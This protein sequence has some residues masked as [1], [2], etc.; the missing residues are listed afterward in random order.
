DS[1]GYSSSTKKSGYKGQPQ[2]SIDN[3]YVNRIH[4]DPE[5][6]LP[7]VKD[8]TASPLETLQIN[9]TIVTAASANHFCALESFLY[10]MADVLDGLERTEIRPSLVVYNLGGMTLEQE[11]RLEYLQKNQYMDEYHVFD[12]A[13]YPDFWNIKVARG[14]YGWKAGIIKEVADKHRGLILWLDSGNMLALDFLR[15]LPGYLD[16]Y[17]FWS[18]QSSGNFIQYTHPGLPAFFGDSLDNYV[19]ETNCNGAAVA[20]DA[21][22]DMIYN[23]LLKDWYTCSSTKECIAP[24]GSS[25]ANHRQDQAA[26][27]YLAKRLRFTEQCRHYPEHYGVTVH[28]DKAGKHSVHSLHPPPS[29]T[30]FG[31]TGCSYT[32]VADDNKEVYDV[33][34]W[35]K[36]P[37]KYSK[38]PTIS[39]YDTKQSKPSPILWGWRAKV[40]GEK[41][42]K[43]QA[44]LQ[45]FKLRLDEKYA[46]EPSTVNVDTIQA[47][48]DYLKPFHEYTTES[49]LKGFG[50]GFSSDKF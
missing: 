9:F 22:K 37:G 31:L 7:Y 16:K 18:P 39:L 6:N 42:G 13:K 32:Y 35:P 46:R 34:A 50:D 38:T 49:I 36:Q 1:S 41:F 28:Q 29:S 4:G 21:S 2:G 44:V 11:E 20:F 33:S 24:K 30:H 14:E 12:Y 48:A 26:L 15:Y 27:T 10:S 25:R 40:E 43:D 3:Q 45:K 5:Q 47:I 23:G 8:R 19:D 17:G